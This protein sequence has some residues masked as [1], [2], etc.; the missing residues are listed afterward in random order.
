MN[1]FS[2]ATL[3]IV[4]AAVAVW[5]LYPVDQK[6]KAGIDL[7]GGTSLIYEIDTQGLTTAEKTGLSGK[8]ITTMR[9]R[10]DPANMQ[11]YIWKQQGNTRFEIQMPLASPQARTARQS[12]EKAMKKLIDRNIAP[13]KILRSLKYAENERQAFFEEI[14]ENKPDKLEILTGLA[15][16]YDELDSLKAQID[17]SYSKM[18]SAEQKISDKK[19]NA[20][21]IRAEVAKWAKVEDADLTEAIKSFSDGKDNVGLLTKYTKTYS[22]WAILT[23]ELTDAENGKN[24]IYREAESRIDE[25]NLTMEQMNSIL[26]M[27]EG[28]DARDEKLK[29]LAEN[30]S[31]RQEQIDQVTAA[32][33]KYRKFKGLLDSPNDLKRLLK[34]A[35]ILEFRIL[36]STDP[37]AS[38]E[39]DPYL[40]AEYVQKLETKGPK[41]ASD[42]KYIWLELESDLTDTE[43]AVWQY[44]TKAYMG[45]FADKYYVL[46]SNQP[47]ET[48]L[49][50]AD[51]K[52]WKLAL[53]KAGTDSRTGQRAIN[54]V[55]DEKGGRLFSKLSGNNIGRPL[56]ILL[57]DIA[58]SAPSINSK[59]S[60]HGQITGKFS[61]EDIS[62]MINKLN[63]G[64]LPARLIEQ[65]V[66]EKTIGPAIGIDNRDK[67]IK[68]GYVGFIV[69]I[70]CMALYYMKLG[71]IADAAL[72]LNLLLVMAIMAILGATFTLPGIAGIILTIGM[73]VDANVL[74]FERIR[75]E[76]RKGS[77]LAIA[78]KNGYQKAFS[79]IFDANLTT[80]ITAA[81]LLWVAPEEIKGFAIVLMLGI[82]SS[83]FT[84]LFATRVV[85]DILIKK[86]MIKDRLMMMQLIKKPNVNW[87]KLRPVFFAIS[88]LLIGSGLF[89]FLTRDNETNNKYGIE[90]TGGTAA[91]L[92]LTQAGLTRQDIE[93]KIRS[94]GLDWD[95]SGLATASVYS[96]GKTGK[97]F[98]INTTETNKTS[99]TAVFPDDSVTAEL[100]TEK[101]EGLLNNIQVSKQ[102]ANTF[103]IMTSQT[104]KSLV[105]NSITKRFEN[106]QLSQPQVD[107]IVNRAILTTFG[108]ILEIRQNLRPVVVSTPQKITVEL[109]DEYPEFIDFLNGAKI[110][111]K[112]EKSASAEEIN[113]RIN[114]LLF[115][116]DTKS[117]AWYSYKIVKTDLSEPAPSD[118]LDAF[119]YVSVTPEAGFKELEEDQWDMFID[120]EKTKLM[121][122]CS[123]E[124]SLPR[125]TQISPSIGAEAKTQALIAIALSLIAI[126]VYI[127]VRFGNVRYGV[128]AIAAL[129]HDVCITLGAVTACTYIASTRLGEILLIGDFKITPAIIAAF[130]TLIGYSLNDTIVV[131]DRIRENRSKN[132]LTAKIITDSIN[133]TI[134]RTIMTSL[135]TFLVILIMYVFGGAALRGFT[136]AIGLGVIV[137]TYSSIAIAAPIL[138]IGLK[139]QKKK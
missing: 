114:D 9:R 85:L 110:T 11:N 48:M 87:M 84:A 30:F 44:S 137:G 31:D 73:S 36:P 62:D 107:E 1:L 15:Q 118:I 80:F 103:V 134:S 13:A 105:K 24:K 99:V 21:A 54:F 22:Q 42:N 69:V 26:E 61:Q 71:I 131:F 79:T 10:V 37:Q 60:R 108:D 101:L 122:A 117:L 129:V 76:Q 126:I 136:F 38:P 14:T 138:L 104:N 96:I 41:Y 34:G 64:S 91:Q 20:E 133:Q 2:K 49:H 94:T 12:Y 116:P 124:S 51:S 57:D 16:A 130:L 39:I 109:V 53:A 115:K 55:L 74:I 59:I 125:V 5:T 97:Q 68:A 66:S 119:T 102:S 17:E 3:I 46:A 50:S 67:G 29:S 100:I 139:S 120:N 112:L 128:A 33:G 19:L 95:N 18:R 45:K 6:L 83:M 72:F 65:P 28:S 86:R 132:Q 111:V 43:L 89:V 35:G 92:N 4:I 90:F 58:I 113:T 135:T 106:V 75:E 25:L 82:V 127:W 77:S 63:A 121:T 93:D 123:L 7:A 81:I 52:A 98:E 78:I 47:T 56:C 27:K 70:I 88:I 8:M 40:M 23:D 32:F